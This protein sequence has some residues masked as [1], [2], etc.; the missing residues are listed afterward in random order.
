LN[1]KENFGDTKHFFETTKNL[2]IFSQ[3]HLALCVFVT[4]IEETSFKEGDSVV[5]KLY[6]K[7]D[8]CLISVVVVDEIVE[9]VVEVGIECA[10]CVD[11]VDIDCCVV[12]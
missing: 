4:D 7:M 2:F 3:N 6:V 1:E 10:D 8:P 11:E 5:E 9:C 12:V